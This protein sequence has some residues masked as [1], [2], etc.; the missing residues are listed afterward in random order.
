MSSWTLDG[1]VAGS[2]TPG[3]SGDA[4]TYSL[5]ADYDSRL[6]QWG[7]AFSEVGDAFNPE[8]G[9]LARSD[10]RFTS[11]RLLR[12]Y[13]FDD[14]EWFR[15]LRPHVSYREFWNREGFTETRLI[16]ID[17]HFEFSNGAFF[18]LPAVNFTEEGLTED[19]EISEGIVIPAGSYQQHGVGIP[20]EYESERPSVGR[21]PDRPRWV[22]L[23]ALATEP[24]P[25]ST[26]GGRI[27]SSPRGGWP[28]STST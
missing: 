22:L 23:P 25:R 16:H 21:G 15:E 24:I 13:R 26:I 20:C 7:A 4:Y 14:V 5:A 18:Q 11:L 6:W 3:K 9:F 1:Y 19:F 27:A 17:S 10:Y 8:V 28:T 12:R 2:E